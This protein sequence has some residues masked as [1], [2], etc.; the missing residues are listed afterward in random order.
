MLRRWL[1]LVFALLVAVPAF[2]R[3]ETGFLDRVANLNGQ[4]YRYQVFVP[5]MWDDRKKWPVI[6]FLH[7]AGERGSDGLLQTDV[8]FPHAIR[9]HAADAAFIAVIPQC[10]EDRFWTDADQQAQA[11][12]ALEAT[13][14]E[15]KGDRQRIYLM[16]LSMGGY[17][18]WDLATK[19]PKLF[20]AYVVICG[21]LHDPKG[22]PGMHPGLLDDR[23]ITDPY[24]EIA[25]H[26]GNTP[27]W[28]FHGE[29]DD[30]VPVAEARK[31]RDALAAAHANAQYTEYPGVGHDSWDRAYAEPGLMPW[32]LQQHLEH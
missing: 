13:I 22:Y 27:V 12:A 18:T 14:K 28:I 16:G 30:I 26:V 11:L 4:S 8:G 19:S 29:A 7:G 31:M 21:G 3:H 5:S 23:S 32:L 10:R 24:A 17:G 1:W 25:R 2:A 20:A 15:F 9:Q 6:L